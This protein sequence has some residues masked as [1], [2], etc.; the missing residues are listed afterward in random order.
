MAISTKEEL[1]FLLHRG[2][3]IEKFESLAVWKAFTA[4]GSTYRRT[5]LTLARDSE[6]HR[7]ELERL[8]KTL[9][10][11][12]PT[13][14]MVEGNFDFSGRHDSEILQEIAKQ[15]EIAKDLYN[16]VAEKTDP[17]LI[18]T[19]SGEK[20]VELFYRTLKQIVKDEER[21]VKMVQ[22]LAGHVKRIL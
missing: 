8:L 16:E 22:D 17:K 1:Q 21:H 12:P 14:E 2:W 10:L 7:L 15:D 5:I 4:V 20:A 19:L 11:E 13:N 18:G 3:E 9:N 6:N